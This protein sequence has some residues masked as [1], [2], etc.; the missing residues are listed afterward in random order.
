MLKEFVQRKDLQY[1]ADAQ[2]ETELDQKLVIKEDGLVR[3]FIQAE[4]IDRSG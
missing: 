3:I 1:T 4:G 2:L